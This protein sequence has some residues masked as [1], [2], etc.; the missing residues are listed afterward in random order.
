MY[1]VVVLF[2]DWLQSEFELQYAKA[3]TRRVYEFDQCGEISLQ[4][5]TVTNT[6]ITVIYFCY[7]RNVVQATAWRSWRSKRL[8]LSP[9]QRKIYLCNLSCLSLS[10]TASGKQAAVF[11]RCWPLSYVTRC[12]FRSCTFCQGK[13]TCPDFVCVRVV[14]NNQVET[15][16]NTYWITNQ[17][18]TAIHYLGKAPQSY[19]WIVSN[20]SSHLERQHEWHHHSGVPMLLPCQ[21]WGFDECVLREKGKQCVWW[22]KSHQPGAAR[23]FL[24]AEHVVMD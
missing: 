2:L 23:G 1:K 16:A 13:E 22:V 4:S 20:H 5:H 6:C 18:M 8:L 10:P 12:P 19:F 3:R 7:S 24:P 14:L 15:S 17:L 9:L 21:L 11:L